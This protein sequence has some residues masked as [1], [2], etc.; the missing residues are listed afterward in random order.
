M[1]D[2]KSYKGLELQSDLLALEMDIDRFRYRVDTC[3]IKDKFI[4]TQR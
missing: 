3:N 2:K 4:E 1:K